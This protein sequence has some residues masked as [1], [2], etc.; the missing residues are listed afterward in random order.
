MESEWELMTL[1]EAGVSLIDCVHKT[2]SDAGDGYPYIA[3]PQMKEGRIDF[4]ANP[5]LISERDFID[6]TK[7]AYPVENDVVLSRRCNPGKLLTS[8]LGL[9][10]RWA[11]TWSY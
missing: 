11:K 4:H 6:W 7:K 10:L 8:L 1:K 9:N 5:R 3:I 2:P